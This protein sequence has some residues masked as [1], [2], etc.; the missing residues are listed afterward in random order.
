MK[1]IKNINTNVALCVDDNGKQLVAF[2]KAI[3]YGKIPYELT[4]LSIIKRTYYDVDPNLLNVIPALDEKTISI[5]DKTVMYARELLN[6]PIS[7]SIVFSLADHI[8]FSIKRFEDKLNMTLPIANE[9]QDLFD[10]EMEIGRYCLKLI[11]K[12]L[13]IK[14]PKIEATYIALHIINSEASSS[15]QDELSNEFVIE[16]ITRIIESKL[17]IAI[18]RDGFNY[19]RFVA[20]MNYLLKRGKTNQMINS[21]NAALYKKTA[22]QFPNTSQVT[23]EVCA[24]LVENLRLLLTD[25]EKLY[26]ILHIN[27]LCSR[28]N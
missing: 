12:E 8:S 9:I 15:K 4:D 18:E 23:D 7:S 13:G 2:G 11:E 19:S 20:H 27:R 14:L 24:Y 5:A 26:L 3:G 17:G 28:N 25:E 6:N 16:S 21:D 22:E 1:V 10:T